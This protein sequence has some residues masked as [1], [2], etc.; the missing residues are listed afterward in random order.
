MFIS[1]HINVDVN[2]RTAS[3]KFN[4]QQRWAMSLSVLAGTYRLDQVTLNQHDDDVDYDDLSMGPLVLDSM[5][6]ACLV[7][8]V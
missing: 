7:F 6:H 1:R 5:Y 2:Q 3:S 4:Q 8:R